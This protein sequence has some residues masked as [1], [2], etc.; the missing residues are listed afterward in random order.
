MSLACQPPPTA[1]IRDTL[2]SSWRPSNCTAP[3][4]LA[5]D[6]ACVV[7]T[8]KYVLVPAWY[9][10]IASRSDN[11]AA[12][13][14][15]SCTW[16]SCASTRKV[17]RLSS[18][19]CSPLKT[20][21]LYVA[22][23]ASNAARAWSLRAWRAPP[24]NN[25]AANALPS[26]QT[27]PGVSNRCEK[28]LPPQAPAALSVSAG[29]HAARA[30]P[31]LALA[32]AARRSALAIS[33]RRSSKS[34]GKP[35]GMGGMLACSVGCAANVNAAGGGPGGGGGAGAGSGGRGATAFVPA[36]DRSARRHRRHTDAV[37]I[38][39][40]ACHRP[41]CA[42]TNPFA[43]RSR[44]IADNSAP[45][46]PEYSNAPPRDWRHRPR[47]RHRQPPP[48]AARGPRYRPP[49]RHS[50]QRRRYCLRHRCCAPAKHCRKPPAT[51]RHAQS[52]PPP[53]PGDIAPRRTG[54]SD[55]PGSPDRSNR[56]ALH[57]DR[58]PTS[59]AGY[60]SGPAWRFSTAPA[61]CKPPANPWPDAHSQGRPRKHRETARRRAR[62]AGRIFV[63]VARS[64]SW[65]Q[66][67]HW[68][69]KIATRWEHPHRQLAPLYGGALNRRLTEI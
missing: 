67:L 3:R 45:A 4:S 27:R 68:R 65:W 35:A 53:A 5:S 16:L 55:S 46:Q 32:A 58:P 15:W 52:Q 38:A 36:P 49:T 54:Y 14:A 34:E 21:C 29:N 37:S 62:Q 44:A 59:A 66:A 63:R 12:L 64:L 48:D 26:D 28:K 60:R 9:W 31:I 33:G 39:A 47:C 69:I 23:A 6:A 8:D 13:T 56:S 25:S 41:R 57:P 2:A 22:T 51:N 20:V 40:S 17:E 42:H 7:S 11:C 50:D 18:T 19:S 1:L 43:N 61:P 30:T 10:L 24:S